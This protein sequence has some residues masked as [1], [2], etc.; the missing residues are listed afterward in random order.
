MK[1]NILRTLFI[2]TPIAFAIGCASKAPEPV[3]EAPP[4][5]VEAKPAPVAPIVE[6]PAEKVVVKETPKPPTDDQVPALYRS[7]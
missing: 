3:M 6:P 7:A 5:V 2:L 4:K 1:S